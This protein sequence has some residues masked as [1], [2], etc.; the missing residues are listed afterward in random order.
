MNYFAYGSNMSIARLRARTPSAQYRG[1]YALEGHDLRFH[2]AGMDGS[3]KCDAFYTGSE[4]HRVYG[5]L[6]RLC[7]TEKPALDAVEGLGRGYNEKTVTVSA[8]DGS[9][10]V[11]STYFATAIDPQLLPYG[12]YL[13]HVLIGAAQASLPPDYVHSKIR[14]VATLEDSDRD[15]DQRERAIHPEPATYR[16][17]HCR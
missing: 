3:G 5:A 16:R 6:F 13:N 1:C 14:R 2:K 7:P 17:N 10:V 11:A 4:R 12:W 8:L 15:R 9:S